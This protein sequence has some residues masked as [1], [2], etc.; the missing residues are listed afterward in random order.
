METLKTIIEKAWEQRASITPATKGPFA[1]AIMECLRGLDAGRYR[2]AE[3]NG[4]T[5]VIHAWLKQAILL[6]FR[7]LPFQLFEA[8]T[9]GYDKVPLK[10]SNWTEQDYE[11][12]KIRVVPGSVIRLGTF[13]APNVVV[14]PSFINLGAYIDEGT[15]I[16]S[17]VTVGSCAQ[18]G[19]SCHISVGVSLGGVLEPLQASPV[20][21]EDNCFI[22]AKSTL[23]EGV[24][25]EEGSVLSMGVTIGASTAIVDRAT[26]TISYGRVP[27]YSVVVPG[28]QPSRTPDGPALACAVIVKR[29][30][31]ETRAKTSLNDLLR[32]AA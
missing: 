13:L 1:E 19:K 30:T 12:A 21:I 26:G 8:P 3:K 11:T 27:A 22:G 2:V 5:W 29:V 20:I 28:V 17:D 9:L 31:A 10:L 14:M 15:L 25:V 6:S 32:E 23:V 7:L 4:S 18:I 16:D 24:V